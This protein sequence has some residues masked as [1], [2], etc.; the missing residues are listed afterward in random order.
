[1]SIDEVGIRGKGKETPNFNFPGA[2][3]KPSA[4]G[5]DPTELCI[6]LRVPVRHPR[7]GCVHEKDSMRCSLALSLF[8]RTLQTLYLGN[9]IR[10]AGSVLVCT[11]ILR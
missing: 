3:T 5:R 11:F 8:D 4:H 10:R 1:M 9:M 7:H 2:L 6:V